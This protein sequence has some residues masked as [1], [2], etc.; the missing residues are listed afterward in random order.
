MIAK[1]VSQLILPARYRQS[2]LANIVLNGASRSKLL[3]IQTSVGSP[4]TG[5]RL[6]HRVILSLIVD[7]RDSG[8]HVREYTNSETVCLKPP[9]ITSRERQR[10]VLARWKRKNPQEDGEWLRTRA[11]SALGHLASGA[12]LN[13]DRIAPVLHP[14]KDEQ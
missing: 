9:R 14:C 1:S 12:E 10:S 7:L 3:E 4:G 8:W 5:L 6:E 13:V 11:Q 2:D